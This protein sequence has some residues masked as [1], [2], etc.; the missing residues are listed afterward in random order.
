MLQ[1]KFFWL[2]LIYFFF[3]LRAHMWLPQGRLRVSGFSVL[4]SGSA[5]CSGTIVQW[6]TGQRGGVQEKGWGTYLE[7]GSC[8]AHCY[9]DF[10]TAASLQTHKD[11]VWEGCGRGWGAASVWN[12]DT[13]MHWAA[14]S[15]IYTTAPDPR[16]AASFCGSVLCV[17]SATFALQSDETRTCREIDR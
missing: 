11:R 10:L 1:G 9:W 17:T 7:E 3:T 6:Q 4:K 13:L 2:S 15:F 5:R 12:E 8:L 16:E 14:N